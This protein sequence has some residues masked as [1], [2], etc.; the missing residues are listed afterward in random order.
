MNYLEK[1]T[2]EQ[3]GLLCIGMGI[4]LVI[5]PL[6]LLSNVGGAVLVVIGVSLLFYRGPATKL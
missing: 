4:A 2:R 6:G 5:M 1:I 3:V